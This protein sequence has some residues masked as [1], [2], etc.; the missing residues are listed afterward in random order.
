MTSNLSDLYPFLSNEDIFSNF[1]ITSSNY[2]NFIGKK[3]ISIGDKIFIKGYV[4]KDDIFYSAYILMDKNDNWYIGLNEI[5]LSFNLNGATSDVII[6]NII[7]R[8][9]KIVQLPDGNGLIIYN[10][11]A[12][13]SRTF[14]GWSADGV[15][16]EPGAEFECPASDVTF[17]A[18][19]SANYYALDN[20]VTQIEEYRDTDRVPAN[21][22]DPKYVAGGEYAEMFSSDGLYPWDNYDMTAVETALAAAKADENRDL[23]ENMQNRVNALKNNLQQAL[24]NIALK[25][26]DKSIPSHCNYHDSGFYDE[27]NNVFYPPC[28]SNHS[29]QSLKNEIDTLYSNRSNVNSLY[30]IE[31]I[32]ALHDILYGNGIDIVG[33]DTQV[34]DAQ[35]KMPALGLLEEYTD[36]LAEAYHTTLELK[37]ANYTEFNKLFTEY[38]PDLYPGFDV[39]FQSLE[40][41]FTQDSITDLRTYYDDIMNSGYTI[42]NVQQWLLEDGGDVYITMRDYI[43]ALVPLDAD[44]TYVFYEILNIPT[45]TE[46]FE[47]PAPDAT[48]PNYPTWMEWARDN[49]GDIS[50]QM[51]TAY[52]EARFTEASVNYLYLVLNDI[53]WNLNKFEQDEVDGRNNIRSIKELLTSAIY[54]LRPRNYT[55]IFKRND[56]TDASFT[57]QGDYNYGDHIGRFPTT[58]PQRDGYIF[59]GWALNPNDIEPITVEERVY[60]NMFLYAI[61]AL[62]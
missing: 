3:Y 32:E 34:M 31:S 33:I 5:T 57:T 35:F 18:I 43:D 23:P 44:Y 58:N 27:Y 19:W 61:W 8:K 47:Y 36:R 10:D 39:T 9:G 49:A 13:E 48:A 22:N 46:G 12:Q 26:V 51:D 15:D 45:G 59:R 1:E 11:N 7:A 21:G 55:V 16:Y 25:P 2:E 42:K 56:G 60:E 62:N 20:L 52:L 54:R 41:F 53:N 4:Q 37:D 38:L 6:E 24:N 29:Y 17:T 30:T 40:E 14:L 28:D 50:S